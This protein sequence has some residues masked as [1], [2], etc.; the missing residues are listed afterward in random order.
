[1]K[2]LHL[3][4]QPARRKPFIPKKAVMLEDNGEDKEPGAF[5]AAAMENGTSEVPKARNRP[6]LFERMTGTGKSDTTPTVELKGRKAR[7][8]LPTSKSETTLEVGD[9]AHQSSEDERFQL[10]QADQ[11]ILEIPTFLRRQ[12]N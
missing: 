6:S 7:P 8:V 3:C 11:E 2:I 10:S 4:S 5:E 9:E 12:A 1:M